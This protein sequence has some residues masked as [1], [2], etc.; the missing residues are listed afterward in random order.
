M[1]K[2]A[3]II[4]DTEKTERGEYIPC[5]IKEGESGYFL[6]DWKWGKDRDIARKLAD[7][8]NT[9]LGIK[10]EEAMQMTLE[11]MRPRHE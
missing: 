2:M 1:T 6:T 7:D 3:V 10:R 5:V 11:S 8:Y 4:I 9:K